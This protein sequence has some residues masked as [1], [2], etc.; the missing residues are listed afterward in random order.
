MFQAVACGEGSRAYT[1]AFVR[2]EEENRHYKCQK[3]T[4][5]YVICMHVRTVVYFRDL[6]RP[7]ASSKFY[8]ET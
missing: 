4:E 7:L 2:R 8:S 3:V 6:T 1:A 5:R